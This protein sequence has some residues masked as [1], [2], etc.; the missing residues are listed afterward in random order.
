M[1][2]IH[3]KLLEDCLVLGRFPLSIL[4]LMNDANYPWLI[5]VP[6]RDNLREVHHLCEEDQQ[7]LIRESAFLSEVLEQTFQADKINIAALGNLVPQLHIHHV[8][9]YETDIAWPSP[10]WGMHPARKYSQDELNNIVARLTRAISL[11]QSIELGE[12]LE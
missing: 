11:K 2:K 7:Q 9:R 5:L 1:A 3:P 4:L 12:I 8:V 10:V 6:D